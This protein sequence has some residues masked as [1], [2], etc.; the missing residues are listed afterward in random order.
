[1]IR[2]LLSVVIASLSLFGSLV[3]AQTST[4]SY[5]G[6]LSFNG[7]TVSDGQYEMTVTLYADQSGTQ[8]VWSDIYN[9]DVRAGV[10]SVLLG[11]GKPLPAS[12]S[13]DRTLWVGVRIGQ[14]KEMRPLTQLGGVPYA[15]NVADKAITAEKI[16]ADYISSFSVNGRKISGNGKS[17][18][19]SL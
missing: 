4:L 6:T 2:F 8:P 15:L 10:F 9:A 7:T 12:K 14:G 18:R 13:L 5:Q 19:L 17:V 3:V 1:M 16:D 11:A